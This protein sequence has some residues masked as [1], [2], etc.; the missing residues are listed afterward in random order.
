MNTTADM[1]PM[2]LHLV[3]FEVL[4]RGSYDPAQYSRQRPATW[5]GS[6]R[7]AL[8]TRSRAGVHVHRAGLQRGCDLQP[9]V[10]AK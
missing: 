5:A 6:A 1:H 3:A 10:H 2:H 4:E 7:A 8:L 9:I